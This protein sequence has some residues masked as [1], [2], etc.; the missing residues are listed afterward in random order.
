MR[1]ILAGV[2]DLSLPSLL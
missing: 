1:R 2:E